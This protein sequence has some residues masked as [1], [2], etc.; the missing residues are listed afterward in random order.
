MKEAI[1]QREELQ[2]WQALKVTEWQ[3]QTL[4]VM[5]ANTVET[6]K[7]REQ[8]VDMARSASLTGGSADT[9]TGRNTRPLKTYRTLDGKEIPPEELKNYS[10]DEI[11]H[12]EEEKQ[13]VEAARSR[14][15]G[16]NLLGMRF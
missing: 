14:N 1:Q 15:K 9:K 8:L 6:P 10:W 3:T 13:L 5:I 16:K 2:S 11:D 4:G 12:S 7:A